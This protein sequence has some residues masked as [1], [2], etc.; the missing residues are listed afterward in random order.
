[1]RTS[2]AVERICAIVVPVLSIGSVAAMVCM[3]RA[4]NSSK[5]P[6]EIASNALSSLRVAYLLGALGVATCIVWI[7]ARHCARKGELSGIRDPSK[8]KW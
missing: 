1:M 3:I 2:K 7:L 6:P 8:R 5:P 4:I